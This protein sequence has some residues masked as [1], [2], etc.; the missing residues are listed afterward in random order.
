MF[1]AQS[2]LEKGFVKQIK[3]IP[4]VRN[5]VVSG[6]LE[7]EISIEELNKKPHVIYEPEQFPGAIVRLTTPHKATILVFTSG[8]IV[9]Y[10]LK[11]SSQIEQVV[12]ELQRIIES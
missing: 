9:I 1:V 12:D 3:L 2:L 4:T 6:D 10:G 8:K 7:R 11:N 5:I